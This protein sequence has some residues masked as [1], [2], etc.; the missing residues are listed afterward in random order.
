M[1]PKRPGLR[2]NPGDLCVVFNRESAADAWARLAP[3][4]EPPAKGK[5]PSGA[6][7]IGWMPH[8]R[9]KGKIHVRM[10]LWDRPGK[11]TAASQAATSSDRSSQ[12]TSAVRT[13]SGTVA[14]AQL[15]A[16]PHFRAK[17]VA[18]PSEAA[19]S[20]SSALPKSIGG[21]SKGAGSNMRKDAP[22]VRRV[23]RGTLADAS[24][25]WHPTDRQHW[26]RHS[27]RTGLQGQ[28]LR[29]G[30]ASTTPGSGS[31]AKRLDLRR[32]RSLCYR[33]SVMCIYCTRYASQMCKV[34]LGGL[35]RERHV[36]V[37]E[38]KIRDF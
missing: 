16:P 36:D 37:D 7:S 15:W 1:A 20:S 26:L 24:Q 38:D 22:K 6:R 5:H 19:S 31:T 25:Q 35:H 4:W 17:T 12:A 3:G 32:H 2:G 8:E 21:G 29:L 13:P 11:G 34:V 28:P 30:G 27:W 14:R 23:V 18:P 10:Q 33:R 9:G